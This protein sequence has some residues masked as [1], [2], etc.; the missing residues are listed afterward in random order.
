MNYPSAGKPLYRFA[1]ISDTHLK[2]AENEQRNIWSTH[3]LATERTRFAV[4]QLQEIE[5]AFVIHL[6]DMIHPV[7]GMPDYAATAEQFTTVFAPLQCPLYT[8]PGNHD[9]G[10][11]PGPTQPAQTVSSGT[12][13]AFA[14]QF[15]EGYG[16]FS[17]E[18]C[19]II[20]INNPVFNSG[21]PYEEAQ[22]SWLEKELQSN[23]E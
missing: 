21:L 12:V 2:L 16:A 19:R 22:W 23:R 18:G 3:Q 8:L 1:V 6:G 17:H 15:G 9:I 10:D 5:P 13:A 20:M 7:P 11:K 4:A 14:E